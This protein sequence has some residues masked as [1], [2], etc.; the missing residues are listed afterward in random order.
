M[1]IPLLN[2]KGGPKSRVLVPLLHHAGII[3]SH[4]ADAALCLIFHSNVENLKIK[5]AATDKYSLISV[6]YSATD[7]TN[8]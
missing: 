4:A 7:I 3:I 2:F 5:N 8:K 6:L 1:R